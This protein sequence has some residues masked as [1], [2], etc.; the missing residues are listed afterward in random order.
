MTAPIFT[1]IVVNSLFLAFVAA[2]YDPGCDAL[3]KALWAL[4]I[5]FWSVAFVLNLLTICRVYF[6]GF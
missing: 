5:L 6:G 2:F 4:A 1:S 3:H